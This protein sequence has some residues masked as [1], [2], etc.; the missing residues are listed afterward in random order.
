MP[1]FYLVPNLL[2]T[3][4]VRRLSE[5]CRIEV[6]EEE[7]L[8]ELPAVPDADLLEDVGE[9]GLDRVVG[10]KE[11]SRELLG[12]CPLH[13]EPDH[14]FARAKVVSGHIELGHPLRLARLDGYHRLAHP[15]V[16]L[17]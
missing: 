9:M 2:N 13:Y 14:F 6:V 4:L 16:S 15:R 17:G 3:H 5:R 12:R 10:D 11:R 8:D 1:S 7:V